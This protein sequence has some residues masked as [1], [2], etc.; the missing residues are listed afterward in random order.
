MRY[1]LEEFLL[2]SLAYYGIRQKGLSLRAVKAARKTLNITS[3]VQSGFPIKRKIDEKTGLESIPKN[4][5][6][7]V[8]STI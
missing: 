8:S 1:S 7:D 3:Y 4:P 5:H 2:N 6:L